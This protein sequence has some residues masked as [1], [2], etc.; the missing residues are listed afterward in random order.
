MYVYIHIYHI[1][2]F[3]L[4]ATLRRLTASYRVLRAST[5]SYRVLPR[6]APS[7]RVLGASRGSTL[8]VRYFFP[9]SFNFQPIS[10]GCN[11]SP[12][13]ERVPR[14]TASWERV[15]RLTA[16]WER[17]RAS[18][19]STIPVIRIFQILFISNLSEPR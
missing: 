1:I 17:R 5:A 2:N 14:L 15:P 4:G 19:R 16:S 3:G 8:P 10:T 13:W 7:Y 6:L 11:P 18:R 9:N 12:S